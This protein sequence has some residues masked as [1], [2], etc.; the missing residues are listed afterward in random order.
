MAPP[1][2]QEWGKAN[3][4]YDKTRENLPPHRRKAFEEYEPHRPVYDEE[5]IVGSWDEIEELVDD[6][7]S[8]S[9]VQSKGLVNDGD[10]KS[11][12]EGRDE[13]QDGE[14]IEEEDEEEEKAKDQERDREDLEEE[15]V[16]YGAT[17]SQGTIVRS[18]SG[19]PTPE[20]E[21]KSEP[22]PMK[23]KAQLDNDEQPPHPRKFLEPSRNSKKNFPSRA[24]SRF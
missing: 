23:R 3:R 12:A 18:V 14:Q 16:D 2:F 8:E 24:P 15:E 17:I 19:Q 22:N 9:K 21:E 1:T 6:F 11:L 20:E 10:V 13:E 7:Y 4:N 5:K